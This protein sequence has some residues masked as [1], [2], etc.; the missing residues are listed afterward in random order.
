MLLHQYTQRLAPSIRLALNASRGTRYYSEAVTEGQ[1]FHTFAGS[2]RLKVPLQTFGHA[3]YQRS[4]QQWRSIVASFQIYT[5]INHQS[6]EQRFVH[7][8]HIKSEYLL[9]PPPNPHVLIFRK[10]ILSEVY[11]ADKSSPPK[12]SSSAI[13][14]IIRKATLRRVSAHHIMSQ[15]V[16]HHPFADRFSSPIRQGLSPRLSRERTT[17][18]KRSLRLL[19]TLTSRSWNRPRPPASSFAEQT[20][21]FRPAKGSRTGVQSLLYESWQVNGRPWIGQ[22]ESRDI[23]DGECQLSCKI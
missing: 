19:T 7:L 11:A 3:Y 9:P 22:E 8:Y 21:G 15:K 20:A 23:F 5:I 4:K 17:R 16:K 2:H 13:N 1:S 18:S 10:S 14:S 6:A 12:I